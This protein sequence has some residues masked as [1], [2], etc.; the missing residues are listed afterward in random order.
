M[1]EV[2]RAE[3]P[4]RYAYLLVE[5]A[6]VA[7][8]HRIACGDALCGKRADR[9]TGDGANDCPYWTAYRAHHFARGPRSC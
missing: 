4:L 2:G 7:T 6:V 5:F 3:L 1:L 9:T 8:L